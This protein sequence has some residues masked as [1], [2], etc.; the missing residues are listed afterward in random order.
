MFC[1]TTIPIKGTKLTK[2]IEKESIYS[3]LYKKIK[4]E[5]NPINIIGEKYKIPNS[6]PNKITIS[7]SK[8]SCIFSKKSSG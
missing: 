3:L 1:K 8:I 7:D 4:K 5:R 2:K 6:Y